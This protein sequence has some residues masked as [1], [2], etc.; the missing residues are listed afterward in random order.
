MNSVQRLKIINPV[1]CD[2]KWTEEL[3]DKYWGSLPTH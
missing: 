2:T 1:K 3:E